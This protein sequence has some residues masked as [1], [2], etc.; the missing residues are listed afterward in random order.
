MPEYDELYCLEGNLASQHFLLK[1]PKMTMGRLPEN[2]IVLSDKK[3]SGHHG[4]FL[5]QKNE[6]WLFRDLQSSNGT[7]IN[8]Q[9]VHEK[10]LSPGDRIQIGATVFVFAPEKVLATVAIASSQSKTAEISEKDF[11][12]K[13]ILGSG[14]V[15]LLLL[16][17]LFFLPSGNGG[18]PLLP[19]GSTSEIVKDSLPETK[20]STLSESQRYEQ[21]VAQ[22]EKL[23]KEYRYLQALAEEEALL[24]QILWG[25]RKEEL[26]AKIEED[27][28]F[29]AFFQALYQGINEPNLPI[30]YPVGSK[31]WLGLAT[32]DHFCTVLDPNTHFQ[33]FTYAWK[34]RTPTQL[35]E[36]IYHCCKVYPALDNHLYA[37]IL[38]AFQHR[39]KKWVNHFLA[40]YLPQH[41][42]H[43]EKMEKLYKQYLGENIRGYVVFR[44]QLLSPEERDR[45]VT[46]EKLD[47]A[48]KKKLEREQLVQ[49]QQEELRQLELQVEGETFEEKM[50]QIES[51]VKVYQYTQA[52]KE[53]ELFKNRL[54]SPE[55][56]AKVSLRLTDLQIQ[57]SLFQRMLQQLNEG[58][59]SQSSMK[60]GASVG[61]LK[62][63]TEE[64][65]E[66]EFEGGGKASLLWKQLYP[67]QLYRFFNRMKLTPQ[68]RWLIAV[69]CFENGMEKE[70]NAT[71]IEV[72]QNDEKNYKPRIDQYLAKKFEIPV[73]EGGF[74]P[75]NGIL[76]TPEERKMRTQG[77]VK[78]SGKWV[79]PE[80]RDKYLQGLVP[81]EG[82]W[83]TSED[84]SLLE[85]G[86]SQFQNKW[87]SR[88]EINAIRSQWENAWTLTT[89]HYEIKANISEEFIQELGYFMEGCYQEYVRFF[90][91]DIGK[92]S[93]LYAFGTFEDYRNYCIE[94]K[95]ED[96]LK[97][98]GFAA[99]NTNAGCGWVQ[100][101]KKAQELFWTLAHEGAH[102]Y[103]FNA[104]SRSQVPSWYAEAVATQFEGYKWDSQ[105]K[106]VEFNFISKR[107]SELKIY[108]GRKRQFPIPELISNDANTLI[109]Q[110]TTLDAAGIFYS[111]S[112]GLY[113]FLSH[114][115][116]ETYK[117]LWKEFQ[118]EMHEGGRPEENLFLKY[119][120][121]HLQTLETDFESFILKLYF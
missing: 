89:E 49:K 55:L 88:E 102:L 77:F 34:E 92:R 43:Q 19:E 96:H 70:A 116:N 103:Y 90:G 65:F 93:T 29:V 47:E 53:Y 60:F 62:S 74:I 33:T 57:E 76:V 38:L 16:F 98:N 63:A 85:K 10:I 67:K 99:S 14:L 59:L 95:N 120:G 110:T 54:L 23:K 41:L 25:E 7:R 82:K 107:L 18:K 30:E 40:L 42:S 20:K 66:V 80:D 39:E 50:A 5:W 72:L 81:Y 97:A 78:Y 83:V 84:K 4:E 2:E 37:V 91:K 108:F 71:F 104:F 87:Y 79:T 44:G 69:F 31:A 51:W 6:Q 112:W 21:A 100:N 15:S 8:G 75:Y 121:T 17:V 52:K 105:Q 119:F 45:L 24:P 36:L 13:I 35:F 1:P 58:Q 27:R 68:D 109:N 11:R 28:L 56:K 61:K 101:Q 48:T 26:S 46:E 64:G 3:C 32:D 117:A 113:Y 111:E 115:E 114:T 9:P 94:T 73:P 86:F 12:F 106:K 118:K 22:I